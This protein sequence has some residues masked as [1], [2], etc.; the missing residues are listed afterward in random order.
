MSKANITPEMAHAG[1]EAL[2]QMASDHG[3]GWSFNMVGE[4]TIEAAMSEVAG[5]MLEVAPPGWTPFGQ[6]TVRRGA[7]PG[8]VQVEQPELAPSGGIGEAGGIVGPMGDPTPA[9][10]G[11]PGGPISTEEPQG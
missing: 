5:R 10:D 11:G 4:H 6:S 1:Y 3:Y 9:F 7:F 2:K 8:S